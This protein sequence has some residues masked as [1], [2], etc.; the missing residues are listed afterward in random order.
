MV[1]FV[2]PAND[3]PRVQ[4]GHAPGASSAKI[5]F[6]YLRTYSNILMTC[7]LSGERSLPFGLLVSESGLSRMGTVIAQSVARLASS[8]VYI[9]AMQVRIPLTTLSKIEEEK[10]H[11]SIVPSVGSINIWTVTFRAWWFHPKAKNCSGFL[12]PLDNRHLRSINS[13]GYDSVI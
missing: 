13:R 3:A 1:P 12:P 4:I 7:W 11:F 2:N 6:T 8:Y 5:Y 9:S 10:K